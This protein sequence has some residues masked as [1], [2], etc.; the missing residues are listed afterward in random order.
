MQPRQIKRSSSPPGRV[1]IQGLPTGRQGGSCDDG[2]VRAQTPVQTK[3][4]GSSS[5]AMLM[6]ESPALFGSKQEDLDSLEDFE[7][8]D[9]GTLNESIN[10]G[11]M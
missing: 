5:L 3:R 8:L 7:A 11:T 1:A 2:S 6:L 9:L 4:R 10:A